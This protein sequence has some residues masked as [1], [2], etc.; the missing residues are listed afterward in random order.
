MPESF[1][2][3]FGGFIAWLL[4]ADEKAP[5]ITQEQYRKPEEDE[6]DDDETNNNRIREIKINERFRGK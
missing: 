1:W 4:N 5:P 6:E 2:E 3:E